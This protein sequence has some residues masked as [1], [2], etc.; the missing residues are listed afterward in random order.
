[1]GISTIKDRLTE[2]VFKNIKVGF[3]YSTGRPFD[4]TYQVRTD[5]ITDLVKQKTKQEEEEK[6]GDN[7]E[8]A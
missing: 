4:P 8:M 6:N 3:S 2:A 7:D 1:M 5:A